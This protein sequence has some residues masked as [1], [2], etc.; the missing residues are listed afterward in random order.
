M[1]I[2]LA[3]TQWFD[4]QGYPLVSGRVSVYLHESDTPANI[5]TLEGD[6]FTPA[7]NP[8]ILDE[9]GRCPTGAIWFD[10]TVVDVKVEAYN[11]IPD[12]YSLVDRYEDGFDQ[13]S[14]T[15][16][17]VVIGMAGLADAD[18]ELG[19]VTVVGYENDHDC[20]PRCFVW[21]PSCTVNEDGGAIVASTSTENG[22]WILLSDERYMPSSYYGIKPGVYEANMAA[23]L[24]YPETVGQWSI[25]LPPVPR[26]LKGTYTTPG[27]MSSNKV[28]SFD[29]GA[30]FPSLDFVLPSI[31]VTDNDGYIADFYFTDLDFLIHS[32][33]YR[34]VAAFW[35]SGAS[36]YCLDE[37]NYFMNLNLYG[38]VD[39]SNKTILGTKRIPVNY[40]SGAYY[41]IAN[42][43]IGGKIFSPT[44]DFVVVAD[45]TTGDS[46]FLPGTWDPGLISQGHHVQYTNVPIL[47]NFDN[48]SRWVAVMVE[49]RARLSDLVWGDW[50]LDLQGRYLSSLNV[51]TFTD[52][53]HAECGTMSI[54]NPN[55]VWLKNCRVGSLFVNCTQLVIE[56]STVDFGAEPTCPS[57]FFYRSQLSSA[58]APWTGTTYSIQATECTFGISLHRATDNIAKDAAL[59][60]TDC[61]FPDN[62][63]IKTKNLAMKGCLTGNNTFEVY[64][65][66]DGNTYRI[67]VYLN[68]NRFTGATPFTF[69]KFSGTD[70][71]DQC[72]DCI[73]NWTII[74]NTFTGNDKGIACRYWSNRTGGYYDRQ[75]I[76]NSNDASVKY[77]GNTGNCPKTTAR[78]I[79]GT[80][81]DGNRLYVVTIAEG[82]K[83]TLY[84][85]IDGVQRIM[86]DFR[87]SIGAPY[88]WSSRA[89]DGNG[90]CLKYYQS[91]NDLDH[92]RVPGIY[93]YYIL[94]PLD[95]GDL[96]TYG[97]L[98]VEEI[99]EAS[100]GHVHMWR[101]T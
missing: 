16:E 81:S 93:P 70:A 42:T 12:S 36:I 28:V 14:L 72:H 17:S 58:A 18:P 22:R 32:S 51:G 15:N 31:E 79:Y 49:R 25:K 45:D 83:A 27:D 41:R 48:T 63:A 96:F 65:W 64:P 11:G 9:G 47:E 23:F 33:W 98:W 35:N 100:P 6:V 62:T 19:V 71:F 54:N 4:N 90:L 56:D 86:P 92:Y 97:F 87:Y 46:V 89:I 67:N 74:G 3:Q 39:L 37:T 38:G 1:K 2:S 68:C 59:S 52:I 53:R 60:F 26:F 7:Q 34:T 61:K 94:N 50:K 66:K 13:P 43:V 75:F 78:D 10:A 95:D 57:M 21:D 73:P 84:K 91:D 20:G 5:Y 40:A 8:F 101:Y 99:S 24:S 69:T 77:Y 80:D 76:A 85:G 88:H 82:V 30:K 55:F 44:A 29:R